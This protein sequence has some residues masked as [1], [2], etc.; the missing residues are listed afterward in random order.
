MKGA[1]ANTAT[2]EKRLT[3]LSKAVWLGT[4]LRQQYE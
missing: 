3:N 4:L 2:N 1:S